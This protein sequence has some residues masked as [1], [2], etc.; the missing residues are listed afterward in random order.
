MIEKS[1]SFRHS[2]LMLWRSI[3]VA[4]IA[5]ITI[6]VGCQ[7]AATTASGPIRPAITNTMEIDPVHGH[8]LQAQ[9]KLP[10]LKVWVG[11]QELITEVATTHT[12]VATGMMFRTNILE[13]EAMLFVFGRPHQA[14]FYMRN[15][16]IPLSCAYLDSEGKVLETHDMKPHE[17]EPIVAATD[18]VQFVLETKQGWFQRNGITTGMVV[19][20]ERGSLLDTFLGRR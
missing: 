10:T 11:A 14:S 4:M 13:N 19:R 2:L 15:V 3:T 6:L 12:Q 20:T 1:K 18:H 5:M 9:P 16:P 8:L 7:K 17:E